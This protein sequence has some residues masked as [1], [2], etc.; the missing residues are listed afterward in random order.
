MAMELSV[1]GC[2]HS[3]KTRR[4]WSSSYFV[5]FGASTN[6]RELRANKKEMEMASTR[7]ITKMLRDTINSEDDRLWRIVAE[8]L[9]LRLSVNGIMCRVGA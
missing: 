8:E 1:S 7:L 9:Q 3:K 6:A 4:I 2:P 5:V